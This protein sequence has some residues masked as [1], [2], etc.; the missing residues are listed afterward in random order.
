MVTRT[1]QEP[2]DPAAPAADAPAG[3]TLRTFGARAAALAGLLVTA[4]VPIADAHGA[5]DGDA[6]IVVAEPPTPH[7]STCCGKDT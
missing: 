1:G 5:F 3:S 6:A 2:N 7:P 4:G